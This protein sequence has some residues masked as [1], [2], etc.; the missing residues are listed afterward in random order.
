MLC[1]I[2]EEEG[3]EEGGAGGRGQMIRYNGDFKRAFFVI[4]TCSRSLVGDSNQKKKNILFTFVYAGFFSFFLFF[5]LSLLFGLGL[6]IGG[7][8]D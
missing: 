2:F 7:L 4:R 1:W 6:G 8:G 3:D 5:P